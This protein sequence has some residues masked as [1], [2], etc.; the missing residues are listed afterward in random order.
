MRALDAG[1]ESRVILHVAECYEAGVGR[2]IDRAV[3]A[4][5]EYRHVLL[6]RG[7]EIDRA[8]KSGLY[9]DVQVLPAKSMAAV[10]SVVAA[11][12]SIRPRVVHAHSSWA[13]VYTR[14]VKLPVPVIYQPHSFAFE[15]AKPITRTIYRWAEQALAPRARHFVVLT[16]REQR[17]AAQLHRR[18]STVLVP[19][20]PTMTGQ[21]RPHPR[22]LGVV[23]VSTVGR[24]VEQKDPAFFASVA[25]TLAT[26]DPAFRFEWI[27]DGEPALVRTLRD[28]GIVVTGWLSEEE[29]LSRVAASSVYIHTA[30]YEGFPL[31]VLDA[32]AAGIPIVARDIPAFEGTPL[33]I[34]KDPASMANQVH[35]L[36][37]DPSIRLDAIGR[38]HSLASAM[39][40][41]VQRE[42]LTNLYEMIADG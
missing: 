14:I 2:A 28:A 20:S 29:V 34:A 40:A 39:S 41:D 37:A 3:G 27:G 11:A 12:R 10:R 19:N 33:L 13:G 24:V 25:Q 38:S 7:Q 9:A 26:S 1:T 32:A 8:E 22:E 16:A 36:S 30:N 42:R 4:T 15:M 23:T 17:L 21:V 6:A 5:P 31:S 18:A 35:R